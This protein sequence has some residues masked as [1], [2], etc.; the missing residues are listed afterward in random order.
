MPQ[1]ETYVV[2]IYRRGTRGEDGIAGVVEVVRN[3]RVFRF[4]TFDGLRRVLEKTGLAS[5]IIR[6]RTITTE[7]DQ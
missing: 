5:R 6:N 4:E 2:R 1:A 3:R 7:D